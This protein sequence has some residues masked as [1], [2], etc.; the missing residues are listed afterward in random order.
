MAESLHAVRADIKTRIELPW[1][2]SLRWH[3]DAN[4]SF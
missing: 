3:N 2:C 1:I 4:E